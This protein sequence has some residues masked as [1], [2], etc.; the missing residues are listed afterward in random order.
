MPAN[1]IYNFIMYKVDE[2]SESVKEQDIQ[3]YEIALLCVTL[4]LVISVLF[5]WFVV[6]V[7]KFLQGPISVRIREYSGSFCCRRRHRSPSY[8]C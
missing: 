3:V 4:D 6:R 2:Y 5:A 1:T 7:L 8:A